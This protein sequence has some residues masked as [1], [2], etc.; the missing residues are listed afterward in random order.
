MLSRLIVNLYAWIIEIYLWFLLLAAGFAGYQFAVPM[1]KA[2]GGVVANEGAL[3][4]FGALLF[5]V[6]ALLA[7]AVVAGPMLL[8]V[9]IRKSVRTLEGNIPD[10]RSSRL[11]IE[12][13]EPSL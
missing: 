11:T 1:L 13:A 10:N 12:R 5:G 3:K 7:L 6:A 9:D 4:I 2:V 8:L